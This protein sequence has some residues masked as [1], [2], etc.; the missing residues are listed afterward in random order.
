M[1]PAPASEPPK[2]PPKPPPKPLAY[3]GVMTANAVATLT[4]A[5]MYFVFIVD[6]LLTA[7]QRA[8]F[9]RGYD[10]HRGFLPFNDFLFEPR[11]SAAI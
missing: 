4:A 6:L 10:R 9:T 3:A 7:A 5:I 1:P 8:A 2:R 11:F